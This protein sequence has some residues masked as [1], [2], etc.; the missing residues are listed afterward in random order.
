MISDILWLLTLIREK[1][2]E[3]FILPELEISYWDFIIYMALA[4]V[5]ITVLINGVRVSGSANVR[6]GEKR[7]RRAARAAE[8]KEMQNHIDRLGYRL[9]K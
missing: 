9:R 6:E 8:R 2:L 1:I 7:E 5:V 4:A 3:V